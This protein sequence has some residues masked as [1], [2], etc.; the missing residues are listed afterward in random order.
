MPNA[1]IPCKN[2]EPVASQKEKIIRHKQILNE[3]TTICPTLER[4]ALG[5]D[6]LWEKGIDG[7]VR[8][9]AIYE[10]DYHELRYFD[11]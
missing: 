8:R 3:W 10:H 11:Y 6:Y 2:D 5:K 1:T 7:W 9:D 4:V